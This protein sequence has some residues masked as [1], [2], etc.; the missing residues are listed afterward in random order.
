MKQNKYAK[1]KEEVNIIQDLSSDKR[2][3][4]NN[5]SVKS[6]KTENNKSISFKVDNIIK[7]IDNKKELEEDIKIYNTLRFGFIRKVYSL[8]TVI[9]LFTF[10]IVFIFQLKIVKNFVKTHIP[11]M[12]ILV[13]VVAFIFL[14][15]IILLACIKN[16][17]RKI[18]YNYMLLFL[19]CLCQSYY[20]G[21]LALIFPFEIV[22]LAVFL[23]IITTVI[24]SIFS[25]KTTIE[26]NYLQMTICVIIAQIFIIC[27]FK[28]TLK[29]KFI[30]LTLCFIS[31]LLF[32]I[33][34]IYDTSFIIGKFGKGYSIDDYILATLEIYIDIIRLFIEILR[35]VGKISR[36]R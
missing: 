7:N 17:S 12:K 15:S 36:R 14:T 31:S 34:L 32:A 21:V 23:T 6:N 28:F 30:D 18:P 33:Y 13:F 3:T 22:A 8:L 4:N 29:R 1:M 10:S 24:I 25:C 11:L 20:L 5:E 35:I 16:L 27:L 2:E 19:I 9:L 26:F